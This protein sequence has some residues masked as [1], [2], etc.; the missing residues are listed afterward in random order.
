MGKYK[1]ETYRGYTITS[2]LRAGQ[3]YSQ[4]YLNGFRY[5][6]WGNTKKISVKNLKNIID[7]KFEEIE[8]NKNRIHSQFSGVEDI[9]NK[10]TQWDYS[11]KRGNKWV[12]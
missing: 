10:E 11:K 7:K 8:D 3:V 6:S 9:M 4:T 1:D 12:K 5:F 2:D